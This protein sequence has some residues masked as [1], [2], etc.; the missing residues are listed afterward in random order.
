MTNADLFVRSF[1]LEDIAIR[2]GGD[3][4]TV[5]AY[6]TVFDTPAEIRDGQGHYMEA[7]DKTAFNKTLADHGTAFR[8]GVFY[9]HGMNL[10]GQ[11]SDRYSMPVGTPIDIRADGRGLLTVTRYNETPQGDE[12]LEVIRSGG[13]AGYSFTGKMIRSNPL[14]PPRGGYRAGGDGTLQTVIRHE[15]GLEEYGPTPMPA[16]S[17]AAIVSVRAAIREEM[18]NLLAATP[19]DQEP[20]ESTDTSPSEA[21]ADEPQKEEHSRRQSPFERRLQVALAARGICDE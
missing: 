2:K 18:R 4:R 13:M 12:V 1:R 5:E 8:V 9:N 21:V 3:G 20:E 19:D 15:L 11:P 16:Y 10:Y 6:A 14:R 7:I 17:Q